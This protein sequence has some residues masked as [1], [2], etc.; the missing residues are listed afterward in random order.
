M[1][2]CVYCGSEAAV[3]DHF[4]PWSYNHSGQRRRAKKIFK[5]ENKNIV[6]ACRECN[7]IASNKVFDT[8]DLKR[9]YIQERLEQK[10]NKILQLPDWA[11]KELLELG[12]KLQ[13]N[14]E[15]KLLAKKWITNRIAYPT[16]IYSEEPIRAQLQKIQKL[17]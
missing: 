3:R 15:L 14:T 9:E 16:I 8:I 17:F 11:E 7:G 12:I 4:I 6:S 5:G 2:N 10:Y 1:N 13:K